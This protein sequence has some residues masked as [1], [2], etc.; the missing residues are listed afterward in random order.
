MLTREVETVTGSEYTERLGTIVCGYDG[1]PSWQ[2]AV[3][4]A[5]RL[6]R[7]S[8][9][10][11][12]VVGNRGRSL[13]AEILLGSVAHFLT[14]HSTIPVVVVHHPSGPAD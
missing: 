8:H 12:I 5:E 4:W 9:A 10:E 6:A 2:S 1:P 14:H 3:A 11:V 7:R 13:L